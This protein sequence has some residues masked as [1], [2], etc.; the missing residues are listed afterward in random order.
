MLAALA[1]LKARGNSLLVVEHD[2][3][4]MRRADYIIDLGPGAGVNGGG[5]VACGPLRELMKHKDS[6]TARC[7]R[8]RE[9]FSRRRPAP[10]R[11]TRGRRGC[12]CAEPAANNLKNLAVAFPLGR[13]ICLT[14]VSGSGKS[15][16]LRDCLLPALRRRLRPRQPGGRCPRPALAVVRRG[17]G[18]GGL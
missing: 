17:G 9:V 7:L 2:E 8:A 15:T 13:F 11:W 6:V 5:V 14:G 12:G 18:A 16:L 4:T 10:A 1:L 3:E